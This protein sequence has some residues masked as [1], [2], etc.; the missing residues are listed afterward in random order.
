[1]PQLISPGFGTGSGESFVP[2]IDTTHDIGDQLGLLQLGQEGTGGPL[3][4]DL[5]N[6][7]LQVEAT[8]ETD[9]CIFGRALVLEVVLC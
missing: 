7:G 6:L 3:S 5:T 4:S 9:L 1:V 2:H 8:V